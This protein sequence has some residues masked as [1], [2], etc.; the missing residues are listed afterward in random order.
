MLKPIAI[1]ALDT[2]Y[3]WLL[4]AAAAQGDSTV[5][6]A[7]IIDPGDADPVLNVLQENRLTLVGILVTHHHWDHTDG[8]DALLERYSVPVY[9]PDS[10]PQVTHPMREG[11]HLGLS[12]WQ[13]DVLAVP[14]HTLDH[15]AYI[16]C[17]RDDSL[18]R[19]LFCGD[20]LFAGGCG[21]LF[22]GTPTQAL[23][24]LHKLN[25][26]PGA[27]EVY[28][29]HEYT[30]TNLRFA[31]EVDPANE[32]LQQRLEQEQHRRVQGI[33]T[34]PSH[35]DLERQTNPFLRAS[36]PALYEQLQGTQAQS[37]PQETTSAAARE[38]TVF[39]ELRRRRDRFQ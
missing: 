37:L 24:S 30:V 18:P 29:A 5:S 7:Y 21:R 27:T 33:P 16:T 39:T 17:D 22:E 12:G 23:E 15:L 36:E 38:L 3:I 28:C 10:V 6:E 31:L 4:P 1:P 9:G 25:Q 35:L 8:L 20:A 19:Q 32:R 14:G 34:L 2:N 13:F 11:D 26:L